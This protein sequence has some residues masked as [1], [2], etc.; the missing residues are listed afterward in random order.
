MTRHHGKMFT[1]REEANMAMYFHTSQIQTDDL[2]RSM[3]LPF[4]CILIYL[5]TSNVQ[6]IS[7]KMLQPLAYSC[8]IH[9]LDI[10]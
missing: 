2:K 5:F 3:L 8:S 1:S 4:V 10:S 7:Q 9:E 6:A